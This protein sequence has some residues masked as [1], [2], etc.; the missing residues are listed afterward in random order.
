MSYDPSA[1]PRTPKPHASTHASSGSDIVTPVAIG[2]YTQSDGTTLAGRVTTVE[3]GFTT[4]NSYITDALN[5]IASLE[6]RMTSAEAETVTAYKAADESRTSTVTLTDDLHLTIPVA[7]SAVYAIEAFLLVEGDPAADIALTFAGPA[8]STGGWAPVA[9][10]LSTSDG[11]GSLRLTKFS[12]GTSSTMGITAAGLVVL[13]H[14]A[15]ITAGTAGTLKLQWA[16]AVTSATPT[17]LRAGSWLRLS[18]LI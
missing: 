16:Q 5:R 14:G 18:R 2:A 10:T 11:T 3:G 9:A 7:T 6:T 8:S 15:L 17:V 13:P 1:N 12:F 4:V